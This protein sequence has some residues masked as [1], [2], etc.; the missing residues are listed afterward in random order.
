MRAMIATIL[1]LLMVAV[2]CVAAVIALAAPLPAA[3][4]EQI[5]TFYMHMALARDQGMPQSQ[6]ESLLDDARGELPADLFAAVAPG[7]SVVWG[8]PLLPWQHAQRI[9][10]RC[11]DGL[12]PDTPVRPA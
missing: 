3:R 5:G 1:A 8:I 11:R 4:C 6:Y 10:Q 9:F 12:P 7:P 2:C